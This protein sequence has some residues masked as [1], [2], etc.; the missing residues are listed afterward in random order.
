MKV[1]SDKKGVVFLVLILAVI[2]ATGVFIAV[3]LSSDPESDSLKDNEVIKT[4]LVISDGAQNAL[5]TDVIFYYPKTQKV[6]L[7][8][9]PGNTGDIFNSLS[10]VSG[11]QGRTDRI[12]AVYHEKGIE[13]YTQ[14]VGK[15]LGKEIPFTLEITL[16]DFGLLTDLLGGMK[17]F[18]P[19]GVDVES[20]NGER[21]LLPGGSVTLD[22]DKIQTYMSYKLGEEDDTDV[23][24]RRQ[25]AVVSLLTAFHE[26]RS[27]LLEKKNFPLYAEKI[28]TSSTQKILYRLLEHLS[29]INTENDRLV[30]NTLQGSL[31]TLPSSQQKL[32]FPLYNGEFIKNVVDKSIEGLVNEGGTNYRY[33]VEVLNG[34]MVQGAA[35]NATIL[36]KGLGN[37]DILPAADADRNDYEHTVI[38]NHM[39][40]ASTDSLR[41]LASFINCKN[42][43]HRPSSGA[44][45]VSSA[46]FTII[47][48]M[49]WDGRYVQGG[50]ENPNQGEE[51]STIGSETP[52]P[53]L[54]SSETG[55][56]DVSAMGHD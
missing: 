48:G 49:D 54:E 38:I 7:F 9:I 45:E 52:E 30:P 53:P 10:D 50:Y 11:K 42:L 17:L 46:D 14:E 55:E 8:N 43:E 44:T 1:S 23:M 41:S 35:G 12:D 24:D 5:A 51:S 25:T 32:L 34:T 36:L 15:L 3:S 18:V 16:K 39:Q 28:K 6:A 40:S 56:P 2:I 37:Y 47:L 20:D 13:A 29:N 31:R 4:M 19:N 26:Q 21:W 22:G 33:V 27:V